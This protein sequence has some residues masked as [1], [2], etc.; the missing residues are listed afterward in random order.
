MTAH[1]VKPRLAK[2]Y[3]TEAAPR[4]AKQLSLKNILAAPRVEKIVVNIGVGRAAQDKNLLASAAA[5]LGLITGQKP[6]TTVAKKSESGFKL[7]RGQK[8]GVATTLRGKRMWEF[9][10]KLVS[11]VLPRTGDF[12]GLSRKSFDGQGNYSLGIREH[13]TFPEIDPNTLDRLKSLEVTVVTT[14]K[15][16]DEGYK[17]LKLLGMPFAESR[18]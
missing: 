18:K 9:L 12:R 4:L 17:L 3:Q 16:D 15:N 8:I 7:R 6:R 13:T 1:E 2:K 14:A 11:V 5:D 10:D